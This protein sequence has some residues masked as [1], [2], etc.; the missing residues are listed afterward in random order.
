MKARAKLFSKICIA[1]YLSQADEEVCLN[2]FESRLV[3]DLL[4]MAN[5][6]SLFVTKLLQS[7]CPERW[8]ALQ[9]DGLELSTSQLAQLRPATAV[10][11][12]KLVNASQL[13][14]LLQHYNSLCK[15]DDAFNFVVS[16]HPELAPLWKLNRRASIADVLEACSE[17]VSLHN[18]R[19]CMQA[20]EKL[21]PEHIQLPQDIAER[22]I[23]AEILRTKGSFDSS[24]I[25][26]DL[27]KLIQFLSGDQQQALL[28]L[29]KR[30]LFPPQ[31]S[32]GLLEQLFAQGL[33]CSAT[34]KL[35]RLKQ[36]A[37][38]NTSEELRPEIC[39]AKT[40]AELIRILSENI[41]TDCFSYVSWCRLNS[42]NPAFAKKV[43]EAKD[44]LEEANAQKQGP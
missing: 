42:D 37:F 15:A 35:A 22:C 18:V 27:L 12:M 2:M 7:N 44:T 8:S 26:P 10:E 3:Y 1:S 9:I 5:A 34:L 38:T 11:L 25:A 24:P 14:S 13:S 40:E 28:S 6:K 23:Y 16:V 43:M 30:S 19:V 21:F 32:V 17:A 36:V 41:G 29:L 33:Q 39:V 20:A 4:P 31:V